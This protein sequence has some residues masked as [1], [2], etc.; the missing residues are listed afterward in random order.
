MGNTHVFKKAHSCDN[1]DRSVDKILFGFDHNALPGNELRYMSVDQQ[2]KNF[3]PHH[4]LQTDSA[5]PTACTQWIPLTTSR[6]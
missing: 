2:N 6:W 5:S 1:K 4:R 3:P